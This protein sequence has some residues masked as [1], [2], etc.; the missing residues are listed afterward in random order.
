MLNNTLNNTTNVINVDSIPKNSVLLAPAPPI[1]LFTPTAFQI[2]NPYCAPLLREEAL[3]F[4]E[5]HSRLDTN[6]NL[7]SMKRT[8]NDIERIKRDAVMSKA[9]AEVL[10]K[11]SDI[12]KESYTEATARVSALECEVTSLN[13]R[14]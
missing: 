5:A 10:K 3:L 6:Y 11:L 4:I 14:V 8:S 1:I 2:A 13:L 7:L 12:H 9:R